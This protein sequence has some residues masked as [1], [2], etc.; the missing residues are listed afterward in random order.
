MKSPTGI[1][2]SDEEY[3]RISKY[4]SEN[5][6]KFSDVVRQAV[7]DY[8]DPDFAKGYKSLRDIS[9][10]KEKSDI[11]LYFSQFLDDF[12]HANDKSKL[13]SDEPVW[14]KREAGR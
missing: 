11:A 2:F 6:L 5:N 1:R 4:A 14:D 9:E 12:T 10:I 3:Q 8:I 7:R 13:I